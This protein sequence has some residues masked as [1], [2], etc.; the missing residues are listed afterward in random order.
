MCRIEFEEFMGSIEGSW[1]KYS[2][3]V[4]NL[5]NLLDL[6]AINLSE[7]DYEDF[8]IILKESILEDL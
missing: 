3:I 6:A 4:S 5:E 8:K 7:A 2:A 1:C